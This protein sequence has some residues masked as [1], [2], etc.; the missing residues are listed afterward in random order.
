MPK[1]P[2]LEPDPL[3]LPG[4][5]VFLYCTRTFGLILNGFPADETVHAKLKRGS[6]GH[7]ESMHSVDESRLGSGNCRSECT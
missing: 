4:Q 6:V 2:L 7:K 1:N 3:L 5:R